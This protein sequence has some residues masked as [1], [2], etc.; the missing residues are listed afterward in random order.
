V[1]AEAIH[2]TAL[3]YADN[4]LWVAN[5]DTNSVSEL[6]PIDRT[7]ESSVTVP[8]GPVALVA[9]A[10]SV[11]VASSTRPAISRIQITAGTG[12]PIV[13]TV[14]VGG[15]PVAVAGGDGAVWVADS[16]SREILRIDPQRVR[17]TARIH[18]GGSPAG[19]AVGD[20]MVWV[21]SQTPS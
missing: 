3:A 13:T 14:D 15:A 5:Y 19:V 1:Y 20:G 2:P 12:V 18:F 11:W 9:F 16:G 6:N 17:V 7:V 21:S 4:A 8:A 10:G